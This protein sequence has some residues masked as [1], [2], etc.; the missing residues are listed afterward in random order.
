M[1]CVSQQKILKWFLQKKQ[2]NQFDIWLAI[3]W[4]ISSSRWS[5][6]STACHD[7]FLIRSKNLIYQNNLLLQQTRQ[8]N[9]IGMAAGVAD[10]KGYPYAV[11]NFAKVIKG[12]KPSKGVKVI[13]STDLKVCFIFELWEIWFF[14]FLC[15]SSLG[16]HLF[17]DT[18]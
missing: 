17:L 13:K 12:W 18:F 8:I 4:Q 16:G 10:I 7:I 14:F 9:F 5:I 2:K 1:W 3:F 6:S 11:S 15:W